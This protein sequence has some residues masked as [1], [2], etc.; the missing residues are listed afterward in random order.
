MISV[1]GR[2]LLALSL[3]VSVVSGPARA[4]TAYDTYVTGRVTDLTSTSS[5]ILIMID[6]GVPTN[7]AGSPYG[8]ILI[9]QANQAMTATI[10]AYWLS[11]RRDATVYTDTRTGAGFCIANQ[12]DPT[13]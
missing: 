13:G 8:W 5:G 3:T 6:A 1:I 7:C 2:T 10:L 4:G 11:G 12:Y 9:P